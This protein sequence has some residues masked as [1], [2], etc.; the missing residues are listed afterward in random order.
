V[1]FFDAE[2]LDDLERIFEFNFERDPAAALAHIDKVRSAVMILNA[3]PEI[4]RPLGGGSTLRELVIS[5][6][7]T[8][9]IALYEYSPVEKRVRIVAIRHQR[10][11][12]Y[13]GR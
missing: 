2:A 12:G 5:H 3:H 11:A 7:K 6:G 13:R 4:G 8:G 9:Y 10:E 1:I